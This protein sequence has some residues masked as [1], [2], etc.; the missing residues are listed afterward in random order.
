MGERALLPNPAEPVVT[1]T[2]TVLLHWLGEGRSVAVA[3]LVEVLASAPF[4]VGAMMLI[5]DSGRIEGSVTGGCVEA[6]VAEVAQRV[7]QGDPPRVLTFGISD[8]L[9]GDAGL[10]CG[11]T[12]R[13]FVAEVGSRSVGT[14]TAALE[15]ARE[16][17]DMALATLLDG[18]A[19]GGVL[20]IVD[21]AR[22]GNLGV[23]ENLER[24]VESAARG[25]LAQGFSGV[26]RFDA[27][28]TLA[29]DGLRVFIQSSLAP[30]Q[31]MILGANDFSAAAA[32]VGSAL[33]YRVTICDPRRPFLESHRLGQHAELVAAW[34]DELLRSAELTP[35]DAVLVFT[36]DPKFDEPAIVAALDTDVGY[37]GALGSRRTAH[38]RE[39]RLRRLG[40]T[41]E[42]LQRL[43]S[44]CGLDIGPAS[45]GET[46]ISILAE[47]ISLREGR[48]A[49]PLV[50]TNGPIRRV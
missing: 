5:D 11:G 8:E 45:P 33:G 24:T 10:M 6:A 13:I 50:D 29:G 46:A 9:A 17:R 43:H 2:G 40:V 7:L 30:A 12:V 14:I 28:G 44:P 37:L 3:L 49:G 16:G 26:R 22:I 18:D 1:S 41:P 39:D 35:R 36:H 31:L 20:G 19:A 21:G 42:Q 23:S 38:D 25:C 48:T 47:I 27:D 32:A 34:P 15:A 4:D